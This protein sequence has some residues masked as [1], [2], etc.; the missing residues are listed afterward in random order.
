MYLYLYFCTHVLDGWHLHAI[1][2]VFQI[3]SVLSL[4]PR[5]FLC[6]KVNYGLGTCL[7]SVACLQTLISIIVVF[8]KMQSFFYFINPGLDIFEIICSLGI[9]FLH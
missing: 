5:T 6:I 9:V 8:C 1:I 7:V 2:F 3:Q 4:I